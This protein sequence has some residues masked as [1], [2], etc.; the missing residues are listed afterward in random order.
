[1]SFGAMSVIKF[2]VEDMHIDLLSMSA[3]KLHG[4][5]GVGALYVKSG[6]PI[7]KFMLGGEQEMNKRGGTTN[8]AGTVGFAKALEITLRDMKV[9][10]KKLAELAEYFIKKVTY[11]IPDVKLNGH[12]TQKAPGIV[13]LS[14]KYIEGESILMLLDL[15]GIA[16]STGSACA[17]GS[18]EKSHVLK[19]MGL[20]H[21][22]TNGAIRFSFGADITNA[23]IDYVVSKLQAVVAKLRA[24][25]PLKKKRNRESK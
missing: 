8:V 14:F 4:P 21:E 6:V 2:D 9:V 20:S 12:P 17:S 22:D 16:V 19:A 18:L 10:N 1:M 11:L 24:M 5:K 7:K 15:E 13:N 3:H 23:D 25:S